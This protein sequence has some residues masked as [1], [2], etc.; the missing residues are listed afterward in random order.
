[1][2]TRRIRRTAVRPAPAAGELTCWYG[3]NPCSTL[4]ITD[5]AGVGRVAANQHGLS[6]YPEHVINPA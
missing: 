2:F 5:N 1:M 3:F 6:V 4:S